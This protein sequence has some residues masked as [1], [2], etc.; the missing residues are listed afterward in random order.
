MSKKLIISL[1]ACLAGVTFVQSAS[2]Q[3]TDV[4][5]VVNE[6]N[7]ATNL[8]LT[9]LRKIFSGV[10]RTWPGGA[11]IKLLVRAP[12]SHERLA[13]LRLLGMSES[14]YKQYWTAQVFRGDADAEPV[15][16][17]SFGMTKE[18]VAAIPGAIGLVE[19]DSVKPSMPIKIVKIDGHMPG[20]A[21]YPLH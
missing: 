12:G 7:P 20:D 18:A 1:L 9:D 19:A 15:T 11:P 6:N 14:E 10:K 13:L 4:A 16:I 5:V 3:T 2:A 8:S 21:G 17:L